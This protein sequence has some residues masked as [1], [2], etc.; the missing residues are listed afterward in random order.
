MQ[1]HLQ[2]I[3][4]I[5]LKLKQVVQKM[6]FLKEENRSLHAENIKLKEQNNLTKN[7]G[8]VEIEEAQGNLILQSE[9]KSQ[10]GLD[11]IKLELEK[12]IVEIDDCIELIKAH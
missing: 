11:H 4:S 3:K 5:E 2:R 10:E 7:E 6:A 1:D 8:L 9:P 12:Y